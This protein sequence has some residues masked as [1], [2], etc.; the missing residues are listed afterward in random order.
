VGLADLCVDLTKEG[1]FCETIRLQR[2]PA[3]V[4]IFAPKLVHV[5]AFLIPA[6]LDATL[7]I[8]IKT[9]MLL[10]DNTSRSM[11]RFCLGTSCSIDRGNG[12]QHCQ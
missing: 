9:L 7:A 10:F 2:F 6:N 12:K 5:G 3:L 11:Q 1:R 4:C 8:F